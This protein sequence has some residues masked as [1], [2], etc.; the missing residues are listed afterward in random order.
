LGYLHRAAQ[1]LRT[2][3]FDTD[4]GTFM[5]VDVSADGK[6]LVFD[7]LGDLYTMPISGGKAEPLLAGRAWDRCARFSP[8]GRQVSFIS[9]RSGVDNVWVLDLASKRPQQVTQVSAPSATGAAAV[10][11]TPRWFSGGREIVYGFPMPPT[12]GL[13]VISASGGESRLLVPSWKRQEEFRSGAYSATFT[14]DGRAVFFSA[15]HMSADYHAPKFWENA[16]YRLDLVSHEL[17]R[18]TEPVSGRDELQPQVSKS[19]RLLAYAR[20][21]GF[22]D[23]ELRV[24]DLRSGEDRRLTTLID[25]DQPV[26]WGNLYDGG[27][28]TYAFT[29]DDRFVVIWY[30]GKLHRVSVADGTSEIIPFSVHVVRSVSKPIRAHYR[31][32]DG[33]LEVRGLRWPSVSQ[34]GRKLVFSAV[35][36]LWACELPNGKPQRLTQSNDFEYMPVLSPDGQCVAYVAFS[37]DEDTIFEPGKLMRLRLDTGETIPVMPDSASYYVPSWSPDGTKLAVVRETSGADGQAAFG[38]IDLDNHTFHSVAPAYSFRQINLRYAAGQHISFTRDGDHLVFQ[39]GSAGYREDMPGNYVADLTTLDTAKLDGSEGRKLITAGNDVLGIFPA[40]DLSKAVVLGL[41]YEAYL[42]SLPVG[43]A[44][45]ANVTIKHGPAQPITARRISDGGALFPSWTDDQTVT[46]GWTDQ[47]FRY[48]AESGTRLLQRV[49]LK[50]PR[51]GGRRV[52]AFR[53]ARLITIDDTKGAGPVIERGT[54]VVRGRRIE[55]LGPADSVPIPAE[56]TMIDATGLTIMPGMVES[57]S[58]GLGWIPDFPS[59]LGIPIGPR[60]NLGPALAYGLTTAWEANGV[61][62]DGDQS[63]VE[64]IEAGRLRGQ[65]W[66]AAGGVVVS[67]LQRLGLDY[68]GLKELRARVRKKVALGAGQCLKNYGSLDRE[69]S[70]WLAEAAR[71]S[72]VCVVV[73]SSYPSQLLSRAAD[74]YM[75][76]H[77]LLPAP[78]YRDVI[79]FMVR[80]GAIWT[81]HSIIAFA[82]HDPPD[83]G[84]RSFL[85][86]LRAR[87]DRR[88]LAKLEKYG[89]KTLQGLAQVPSIPYEE[90][91]SLRI[92]R[93]AAAIVAAGGKVTASSDGRHPVV[94]HFEMW[95]LHRGGMSTADVLRAATMTGAEKLGLQDDVGSLAPDKLADF[96]VLT[97]NPLEKIENTLLLK[98][99][100]VDGV[101]YD[102]DTLEIL[103]AARTLSK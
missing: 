1:P 83:V 103:D 77:P 97:A 40:P 12:L 21:N 82:T 78:S 54:I 91:E 11:G 17:T 19:G 25:A 32:P 4:E 43:K 102:S 48:R 93:V 26:S 87:D 53:N 23:T 71:D 89:Q 49:N 69:R 50:V 36:S 81:P 58:H 5:N 18:L 76:D 6:T 9:D 15:S 100:V 74:G 8:D 7:L 10:S 37:H 16:L 65:R 79:Q 14:P 22:D 34:D 88:Q 86:E 96:L 27:I 44:E 63:R 95:A 56:A 30:H 94:N 72:G 80:T 98:Y 47:V 38:W 67:Y 31:I 101:I 90:T 39:R 70:Q 29:S 20:S 35:G 42:V 13:H 99:T 84:A 52:V 55:A 61:P 60:Q 68:G 85:N 57:H 28:P 62:D 45:P 73:H 92:A 66:F 24:R 2:I 75:V 64:L 51:R 3:A 41:D 59:P 33:P 46:Y